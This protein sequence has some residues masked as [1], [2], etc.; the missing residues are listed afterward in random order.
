MN[1]NNGSGNVA[2]ENTQISAAGCYTYTESLQKGV[3]DLAVGMSAPGGATETSL[4][5][6]NTPSVVTSI[7]TRSALVGAMLSD[8]VS[9]SGIANAPVSGTW[10]LDGPVAPGT[11]GTCS[12]AAWTS[13]PIFHS[14]TLSLD[15]NGETTSAS[16]HAATVAG[17][18]TFSDSLS[19]TSTTTAIGSTSLGLVN[20]TAL[21]TAAPTISTTISTKSAS[22]GA[23]LSD[24]V[25]VTG[26]EMRTS[27]GPGR[28]SVRQPL[29]QTAPA[30]PPSG[31]ALPPLT[32]VRLKQT[33]MRR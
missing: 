14:G 1:L 27:R 11:D 28:S 22:V 18:Y 3:N 26:T 10:D 20:E 21:V 4:V 13:A 30:P 32:T 2:L 23:E 12:S 6:P 33:A 31:T 17:C 25:A 24:A 5:V 7:S 16:T 8:T 29:A 9:V 19:A 15:G